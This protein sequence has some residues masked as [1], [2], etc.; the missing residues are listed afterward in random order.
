MHGPT[1]NITRRGLSR[2]EQLLPQY[3]EDA[4]AAE[5]ILPQNEQTF[6]NVFP[7]V[8]PLAGGSVSGQD[9]GP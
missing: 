8:T 7:F 9:E 4:R 1:G 5:N 3:F 6:S 2:L